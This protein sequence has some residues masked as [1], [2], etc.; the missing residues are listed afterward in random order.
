VTDHFD[1]SP[2]GEVGHPIPDFTADFLGP[3]NL[4][5]DASSN[6]SQHTHYRNEE[7]SG[8]LLSDQD[9]PLFKMPSIWEDLAQAPITVPPSSEVDMLSYEL[10]IGTLQ[11]AEEDN[12]TK[13]HEPILHSSH[14]ASTSLA[15]KLSE[16]RNVNWGQDKPVNIHSSSANIS[17]RSKIR[18]KGG[19][20]R[21]SLTPEI[22]KKARNIRRVRACLSCWLLKT[23]VRSERYHL[24]PHL[25]L[26]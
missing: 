9:F 25:H 7:N 1:T 4:D 5:S 11:E 23:P 16:P 20:R 26:S 17:N 22:A 24:G 14:S 18:R 8:Q 12:S 21:G 6:F 13:R 3:T 15:P 10:G 2:W 19:S